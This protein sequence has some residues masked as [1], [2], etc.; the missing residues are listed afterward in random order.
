MVY[1]NKVSW[2]LSSEVE[3]LAF[4]QLVLGSNP[5]GPTSSLNSMLL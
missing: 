4:N 3:H 2:D 5:R 1:T